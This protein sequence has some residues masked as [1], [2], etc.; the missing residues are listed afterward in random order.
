MGPV[1]YS[2]LT[3][4]GAMNWL[5]LCDRDAFENVFA[6]G[7]RHVRGNKTDCKVGTKE[8]CFVCHMLTVS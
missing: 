5:K 4:K 6:L 1:C 2:R 8:C 7:M 3:P